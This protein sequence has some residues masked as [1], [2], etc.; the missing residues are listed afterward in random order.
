MPDQTAVPA[1]RTPCSVEVFR[2]NIP[3]DILIWYYV[4][5]LPTATSPYPDPLDI[6][7]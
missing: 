4:R 7:S 2:R 6:I 3:G 1:D 5:E